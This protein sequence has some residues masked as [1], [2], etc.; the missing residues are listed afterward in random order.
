MN[1]VYHDFRA[2]NAKKYYLLRHSAA[3]TRTKK[4]KKQRKAKKDKYVFISNFLVARKVI[5]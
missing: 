3:S 4:P 5:N 1:Y 2:M